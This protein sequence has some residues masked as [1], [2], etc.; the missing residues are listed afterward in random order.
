METINHSILK[1][2]DSLCSG[3]T[4]VLLPHPSDMNM[5]NNSY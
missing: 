4:L 1:N 3:S 2:L 5:F